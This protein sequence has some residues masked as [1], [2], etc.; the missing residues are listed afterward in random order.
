ME[1]VALAVI[2]L[3]I[4]FKVASSKPVAVAVNGYSEVVEYKV[5]SDVLDSRIDYSKKLHKAVD[6]KASVSSKAMYDMEVALGI[7]SSE[8][9]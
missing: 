8:E 7:I 4:F 5:K 2:A 6:T 1:Y 9:A 3:I